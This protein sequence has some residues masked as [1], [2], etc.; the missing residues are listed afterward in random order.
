[1]VDFAR[2]I[3]VTALA[4]G[5]GASNPQVPQGVASPVPPAPGTVTFYGRPGGF[6]SLGDTSPSGQAV[7]RVAL[8]D[9]GFATGRRPD[10]AVVAA[11]GSVLM[12]GVSHNDSRTVPTSGEM[13]IGAFDPARRTMQTVRL[14]NAQG[15]LFT[16]DPNGYQVAPTVSD[17]LALPGGEAA[18]LAGPGGFG[19]GDAAWPVFGLLSRHDGR[20][21]VAKQWTGAQVPLAT[22]LGASPSR[23]ARFAGSGDIIV[24]QSAGSL[25]ALR[26]S[27][28][29]LSVRVIAQ[30]ATSDR[31]L[32][33][34][35][36]PASRPGAERFVVVYESGAAQEF[37]YD[38][39]SGAIR[40]QSEPFRAP[41][42]G[43]GTGMYDHAGNLWLSRS[44]G[45]RGGNLAVY[46][47][48][49][50]CAV[51]VCKPD[52]DLVQAGALPPV[53]AVIEDPGS[54]TVAVLVQGGLLMTIRA[55]RADDGL[56][57]EA[58]NLVDLGHKLL[59]TTE[60]S[61]IDS[62][63]GGFGHGGLLWFPAG[64]VRPGEAGVALDHWLVSVD[65]DD[66]FQPGP[67]LLP[68]VPG[69]AVTVQAERTITTETSP[70]PG[71]HAT[72]DVHATAHVSPCSDDLAGFS[73]G[74]DGVPGNGF[75]LQDSSPYG[76]MRGS[77]EYR[78]QVPAA[79]EYR[80][81][82]LVSTLPNTPRSQIDLTTGGQA[83]STPV[84]EGGG[85]HTVPAPRSLTLAAG[86]HTIRLSAARDQG[87]WYLNSF[88]LQRV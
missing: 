36:D 11:D 33:V 80:L 14:A 32:Q 4:L 21:V 82:Y 81:S 6:G 74:Y 48:G 49:R 73:C 52:Y 35:T 76:F 77:V 12:A 53:R 88:T 67:V 25:A 3:A 13:V 85:W 83:V 5:L 2:W 10:L 31:P 22:D 60:T 17:L 46:Q 55:A 7:S 42:M 64:R 47:S 57:F 19:P 18:F 58:G 78:V 87:G 56:R 69:R 63:L 72:F 75:M 62:M 66:L 26:L 15:N 30:Q 20:W 38:A 39:G 50:R 29:D 27:V 70:R 45:R 71:T 84:F 65:V 1:V 40:P 8:P 37:R 28:P 41:D 43:F 44:E 54:A 23:M 51:R 86:V 68:A 16:L 34:R 9:W 24:A 79:G 61:R 59:A